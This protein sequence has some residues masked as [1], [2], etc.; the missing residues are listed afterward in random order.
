MTS[1]LP[2]AKELFDQLLNLQNQ[3]MATQSELF[4]LYGEELTREEQ[5]AFD[6]YEKD[7]NK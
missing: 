3:M 2:R 7:R 5:I 6:E 1:K 4:Q